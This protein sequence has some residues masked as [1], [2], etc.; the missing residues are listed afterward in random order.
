[1]KPYRGICVFLAILG[2]S[3]AADLEEIFKWKQMSFDDYQISSGSDFVFVGASKMAYNTYNSMPMG[4]TH[5]NGRLF[6][7]IPRRRSGVPS[8]L[9]VIPLSAMLTTQS[10]ALRPYPSFELNRLNSSLP[11]E[12]RITSVYRSRMDSCDRLWFADS[13]R[14]LA[15]QNLTI[16]VH[17][18]TLWAIDTNSDRIVKRFPFPEEALARGS[19]TISLAVDIPNER[20]C[21][22]AF[23]YIP[24]LINGRIYVYSLR[25]NRMWTFSHNYF[26]MDPHHGDLSIAGLQFQWD[27]GIFSIALGRRN[28]RGFRTA[29]FHP[30]VS[31]SEFAVSTE[32]LRNESLSRREYHGEDFRLLGQRGANRQSTLHDFDESTGVLFFAEIGRN[33]VGCWNTHHVFAPENFGTVKQDK[34]TFIYPSDLSVDSSGRLWVMTNT[35]PRW[36]Y[37]RLDTNEY[38]IRIW[39]ANTWQAIQ[40]TVCER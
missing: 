17:S 40:G 10:P 25:E 16:E 20:D 7:T 38:N 13:G 15:E 31:L 27:D 14:H 4:V 3:L 29:Y 21:G 35:M 28:S 32:V 1:M 18:P 26:H 5:H 39:S 34:D 22:G 23:V 12:Q 9:N 36:F 24:D 19:G 33:A 11:P 8:T 30:M 2:V 37:T 6:I